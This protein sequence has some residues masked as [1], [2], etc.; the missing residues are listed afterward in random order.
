[1]VVVEETLRA[2]LERERLAADVHV[3]PRDVRDLCRVLQQGEALQ[4]HTG[5]RQQRKEASRVGGVR[6]AVHYTD[7]RARHCGQTM[8]QVPWRPDWLV[9]CCPAK[10]VLAEEVRA[11]PH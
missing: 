9:C 11:P 10:L 3:V 6:P 5:G 8:A 4:I 7:G 1:M 2:V